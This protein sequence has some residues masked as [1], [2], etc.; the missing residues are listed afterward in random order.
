MTSEKLISTLRQIQALLNEA[1]GDAP[2]KRTRK[3]AQPTSPTTRTARQISFEMSTL[4]FMNKYA[5]GLSGP[6]KFTLLVARMVKGNTSGQV[7]YQDVAAQWN[8]MRTVL[9]GKCNAAH[10]NRA[11]AAGWVDSDKGGWKL[12]SSWKDALG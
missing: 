3:P 8:K 7:P 9:G 2:A 4:A 10:G 6:K 5:R 1:L 11:K 12:T